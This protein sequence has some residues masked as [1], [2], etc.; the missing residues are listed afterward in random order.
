MVTMVHTLVSK[1]M[2]LS[3]CSHSV[4]VLTPPAVELLKSV[5]GATLAVDRVPLSLA[6]LAIRPRERSA[7]EA[8][9]EQQGDTSPDRHQEVGDDHL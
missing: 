3:I 8:E 2:S 1:R 4:A 7:D 5:A 6:A 9:E